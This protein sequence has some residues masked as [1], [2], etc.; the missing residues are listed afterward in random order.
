MMRHRVRQEQ[1]DEDDG[2]G[3][4]DHDDERQQG[5]QRVT[6]HGSSP[7]AAA[8]DRVSRCVDDRQNLADRQLR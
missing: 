2:Q 6:V 3:Q 4:A 5:Q 8:V 1:V 7:V